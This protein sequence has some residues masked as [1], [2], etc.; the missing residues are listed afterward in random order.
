MIEGKQLWATHYRFMNDKLEGSVLE[1]AIWELIDGGELSSADRSFIAEMYR[2][3]DGN[4]KFRI[5]RVPDGNR[6]LLCAAYS[7]DE[8]TLWRNYAREEVSFAVGIDPESPLGVI[9][10]KPGSHVNVNVF[11][12]R[13]VDYQ[14]ASSTLPETHMARIR[15]ALDDDDMGARIRGMSAALR[16]IFCIVKSDAFEDE[17]ESRVVC[18]ADNIRLW[19]FRSG[20]FGITPYVAL[21]VADSWGEA[22]DGS[23]PLPIRAIRLSSNASDADALAVNALLEVNGFGGGVEVDDGYDASGHLVA[24]NHRE[25]EPPV[26]ISHA[27][28]SLRFRS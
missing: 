15:A 14:P 7:G 2:A 28:N 13:K 8:L 19:R 17:R 9:P 23:E 16:D 1:R 18:L 10:P 25:I 12:W 11:P 6:F 21:G 5:S 24:G 3:F 26:R 4:A 20:E 22:S 27:S